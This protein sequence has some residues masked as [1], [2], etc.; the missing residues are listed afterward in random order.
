MPT[1]H[2]LICK[3]VLLMCR[4]VTVKTALSVALMH[5]ASIPVVIYF[6]HLFTFTCNIPRCFLLIFIFMAALHSRCGHY[7]FTLWFL[8][9]SSCFPR[10]ISAVAD[11]MSAI[12]SH[13]TC[14][15]LSANLEC[16]SEMCCTRLAGNAGPKK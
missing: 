4:Y 5:A 9:F 13:H 2:Q 8:L 6:L 10:L 15:G 16:R 1:S 14:C 12:L 11:W 3:W 7:I